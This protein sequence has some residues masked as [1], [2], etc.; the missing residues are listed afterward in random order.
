[1]LELDSSFFSP[2]FVLHKIEMNF[3]DCRPREDDITPSRSYKE[4]M[5]MFLHASLYL[6]L[7]NR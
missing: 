2:L 7:K 6:V 3:Q 5:F 4:V 1:M